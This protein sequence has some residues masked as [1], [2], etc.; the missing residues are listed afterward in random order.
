MSPCCLAQSDD[1]PITKVYISMYSR[2]KGIID[3]LR[4]IGQMIHRRGPEQ[5]V[6]GDQGGKQSR[7][8]SGGATDRGRKMLAGLMAEG[9]GD[10]VLLLRIYQV[11][12]SG[13]YVKR[14][15]TAA[16]YM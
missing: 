9:L 1:A 12:Q 4:H 7:P 11:G 2:L 6:R 10:Q 13:L 8:M 14:C 3:P 15:L 5:I 16:S